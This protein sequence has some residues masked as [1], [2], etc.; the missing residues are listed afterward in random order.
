MRRRTIG[1]TA[2]LLVVGTWI[3]VAGAATK[4]PKAPVV[5]AGTAIVSATIEPDEPVTLSLTAGATTWRLDI[6]EG[7]VLQP[8]T[9]S[10]RSARASNGLPAIVLEPSG[11]VLLRPATLTVTGQRPK[12]LWSWGP[13]GHARPLRSPA[14]GGPDQRVLVGL[15][16]IAG[17]TTTAV[18]SPAAETPEERFTRTEEEDEAKRP[19]DAVD[20]SK[21]E[22]IVARARS[23]KPCRKG[24]RAAAA[25]A[26]QTVRTATAVRGAAIP[27]PSCLTVQLKVRAQLEAQGALG[28]SFHLH[29]SVGV[30]GDLAPTDAGHEGS[31]AAEAQAGGV[32][33]S[34][35]TGTLAGIIGALAGGSGPIP[36]PDPAAVRCSVGA[37]YGGRVDAQIVWTGGEAAKLRLEPAPPRYD[38]TC[39]SATSTGH[40]VVWDLIRVWLGLAEGQPIEL[41]A[42]VLEGTVRVLSPLLSSEAVVMRKGPA[43]QVDI[44]TEGATLQLIVSVEVSYKVA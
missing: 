25:A 29:E 6:Q 37:P 11:W 17:S 10:M 30:T 1:I 8:L 34:W 33:A 15:G 5:T 3:P 27:V 4:A 28:A 2:L 26:L 19:D 20:A 23:P 32:E 36:M 40:F 42:P 44:T 24:D 7:S 14:G 13:A 43:T 38:M 39:G 21:A 9:L 31:L 16:T 18:P 22:S 12:A 41:D 35:V